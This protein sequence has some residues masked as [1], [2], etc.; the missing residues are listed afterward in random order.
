MHCVLL[1]LTYLKYYL[2]A[3]LRKSDLAISNSLLDWVGHL[4]SVSAQALCTAIVGISQ[5]NRV[6]LH[7]VHNWGVDMYNLAKYFLKSP[8][9]HKIFLE[10]FPV[11]HKTSSSHVFT[12]LEF[13][14]RNLMLVLSP[15]IRYFYL[16]I[17]D[18]LRNCLNNPLF[19]PKNFFT[20]NNNNFGL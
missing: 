5:H 10:M 19:L 18:W 13:V 11:Y 14:L 15:Q 4:Q 6:S 16:R 1:Y 12:D 3:R 17:N 20:K 2:Q 9:F 8:Q 7:A